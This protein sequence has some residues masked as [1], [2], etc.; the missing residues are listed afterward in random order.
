M[1][2]VIHGGIRDQA[3]NRREARDMKKTK[4]II[5][6]TIKKLGMTEIQFAKFVGLTQATINR[7]RN[8]K[9]TIS[10]SSI[11]YYTKIGITPEEIIKFNEQINS[12]RG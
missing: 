4:N 1:T 3:S 7:H 8:M 6:K 11:P 2:P 10:A 5:D 9:K 12:M